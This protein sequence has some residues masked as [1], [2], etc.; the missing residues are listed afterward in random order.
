[1]KG[2]GDKSQSTRKPVDG[3]KQSKPFVEISSP[4]NFDKTKYKTITLDPDHKNKKQDLENSEDEQED[5]HELDSSDSRTDKSSARRDFEHIEPIERRVQSEN[6]SL[7]RKS[8]SEKGKEAITQRTSSHRAEDLRKTNLSDN[9]VTPDW[10]RHRED[11]VDKLAD[12]I[13]DNPIQI[14]P[15]EALAA[16]PELRKAMVRKSR[17]V[18]ADIRNARAYLREG[19]G[20]EQEPSVYIENYVEGAE[21]VDADDIEIDV[22]FEVLEF[23]RGNLPQGAIVQKDVVEQY[24]MELPPEDRGKIIIVA[25]VAE[26]LRCIFPEINNSSQRVEVILDSGSQIIAIDKGIAI[27]IGLTWDPDTNIYMQSANGNLNKTQGLARNVP[28]RFGEITIYLQL[29]VMDRAPYQVLLGRPFDVI[30][31]STVQN[32]EDGDQTITITCPNT[33]IRSTV[34]TYARGRGIRI[35]KKEEPKL[36][37]ETAEHAQKERQEQGTEEGKPDSEGSVNFQATLRN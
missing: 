15:K 33:K 31:K 23:A 14:T 9:L 2:S 8:A 18:R 16:S 24:K 6:S 12:R 27:G 35:E 13:L 28:F 22:A 29:H 1:M 36:K 19:L 37:P 7:P 20:L 25:R 26:H 21:I 34:P 10:R 5:P 32:E 4:K 17:D 3:P 11:I 30:T